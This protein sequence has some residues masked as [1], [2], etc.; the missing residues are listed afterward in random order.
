MVE[1][2]VEYRA[3]LDRF[4]GDKRNDLRKFEMSA[5]EWKIAEQLRD[6][7]STLKD[8]M[9][10]FSRATPNLATVIPAMDY[11]DTQLTTQG[12]NTA[13]K[14]LVC[15]AIGMA[16]KTL[17][18]Y[19]TLT[20]SSEVYRIAMILHPQHKLSYFKKVGWPQDWIDTA[21][22][23]L[24]DEYERSYRVEEVSDNS[25]DDGGPRAETSAESL[26]TG[27]SGGSK[28]KKPKK[29]NIFDNIPALAAPTRTELRDEL[30]RYLDSDP[31]KVENVLLWWYEHHSIYPC[32]SCMALDYLCIPATS[33]DVERL[34]SRG[35]LLLPHV[36]IPDLNHNDALSS[37]PST[38]NHK[39]QGSKTSASVDVW[40]TRMAPPSVAIRMWAGP[41]MA[42]ISAPACP[43]LPCSPS[44]PRPQP[45]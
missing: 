19:Y 38:P 28:S 36:L 3:A 14:S 17:N 11:I 18:R 45:L 44:L 15:A 40:P 23:L 5:E 2:A 30:R 16:K 31:E 9:L 25:D 34:F 21:E 8:A 37:R 1:F 42:S 12:H 32:L 35:C 7:L 10:F 41:S 13:L 29:E 27:P 20:D 4:T 43:S 39:K 24:T 6:I 33:M 26:K 22:Q